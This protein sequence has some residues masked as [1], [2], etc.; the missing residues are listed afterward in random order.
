MCVGKSLLLVLLCCSVALAAE[1]LVFVLFAE[2]DSFFAVDEAVGYVGLSTALD[3]D[4]MDFGHVVG[5]RHEGW[6]GPEWD[7]FEVHVETGGNDA[8]ALVGEL[9][10]YIGQGVIEEL[11]FVDADDVAVCSEKKD[12]LRVVDWGGMDGLAFMGDDIFVRVACVDG[13]LEDLDALVGEFGAFH[14]ADE[15]FGL[16]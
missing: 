16:A 11:C 6:H 7:A 2:E 5:Y 8:D 10:A 9:V 12:A 13:W 3:T 15:F 14:P 4:G 1:W